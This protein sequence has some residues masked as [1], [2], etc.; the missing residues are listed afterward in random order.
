MKQICEPSSEIRLADGLKF[1]N[2]EGSGSAVLQADRAHSLALQ[3]HRESVQKV[4]DRLFPVGLV[5]GVGSG[6]SGIG[7]D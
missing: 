1:K 2:L 6:G 4:S 7:W 3:R 5:L